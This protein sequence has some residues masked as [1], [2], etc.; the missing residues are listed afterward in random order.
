[1]NI[2][3]VL[4]LAVCLVCAF[5]R[6]G[7][8]RDYD[9]SQN[10]E[11]SN[12]PY[13]EGKPYGE[14]TPYS[15]GKPYGEGSHASV[16]VPPGMELVNIGG[17]RMI[18]PQGTKVEKKGSLL[19]MEGVDE[20]VSRNLREMMARLEKMELNQEDLRKMVDELKQE[21]SDLHKK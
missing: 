20:F 11:D 9:G 14:G 7:L 5:P 13:S 3:V 10:K 1:M 19:V 17:I 8:A 6:C 18:I 12:K 2:N 4:F 21:V 16:E 15:E